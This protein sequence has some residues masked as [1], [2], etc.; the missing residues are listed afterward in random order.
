[1]NPVTTESVGKEPEEA[2][3]RAPIIYYALKSEVAI[4]LH[5]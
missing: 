1:M 2:I 4:A 5:L 3:K